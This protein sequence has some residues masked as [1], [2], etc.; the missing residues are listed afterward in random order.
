MGASPNRHFPE[1]ANRWRVRGLRLEPQFKPAVS[2][3]AAVF[4]SPSNLSAPLSA[5]RFAAADSP[6]N[7]E[8]NRWKRLL[9]LFSRAEGP[10]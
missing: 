5:R 4:T 2:T 9:S 3:A 1:F 8:L 10:Y 6:K 7:S